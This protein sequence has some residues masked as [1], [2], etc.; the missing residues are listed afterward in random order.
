[1][2]RL[3]AFF[4]QDLALFCIMILA[5]LFPDGHFVPCWLVF[6]ALLFAL[7]CLIR[8]FFIPTTPFSTEPSTL[9]LRRIENLLGVCLYSMGVFAQLYR[10][11]HASNPIGRQQ[12]KWAMFGLMVML[13]GLVLFVFHH[14]VFSLLTQPGLW[15]V[16]DNL[17]P[18]PAS[19]SCL[20][21]CSHLPL[22]SP[23]YVTD[24]GT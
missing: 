3:P 24:C 11:T 14:F 20:D 6:V 23:Y 9:S 16:M 17:I 10:Y 12:S 2:W 7:W 18:Y 22:G 15:H 8:P 21:S 5:F 19:L 4:I 13:L 1:M